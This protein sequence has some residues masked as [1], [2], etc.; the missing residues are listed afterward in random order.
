MDLGQGTCYLRAKPCI[1]GCQMTTTAT[2][3]PHP[4]PVAAP[5]RQVW[6]DFA[7]GLCIALVVMVH[8][9][10]AFLGDNLPMP[11]A[12]EA[13]NLFMDPFRIPLLMF[14]SGMLLSKSLSKPAG[15]YFWG[16]FNLIFWPFLIWSQIIYASEGRLTLEYILKTPISAPSVLWYLWFLTA[17]YGLA[18]LINRWRLPILPIMAV[19]L[20]ASELLPSFIRMDRFAALFVMF[21]AGHLAAQHLDRLSGRKL[22]GILGLAIAIAGGVWSVTVAPIKYDARFILVPF[23]LIAFILAFAQHYTTSALTAPVE[24]IGRNS[25]LFYAAHM[26][27]ILLMLNGLQRVEGL[28]PWAI[29]LGAFAAAMLAGA[30]LQVLRTR[31]QFVAAL[32]D[33]RIVAQGWARLSRRSGRQDTTGA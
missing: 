12:L 31:S 6:M 28:G 4:S 24:W 27:I 29:Y 16:K 26:P 14:L 25:M 30:L 3:D 17:F 19:S 11:P 8:T 2:T 32:F 20:I 9:R 5:Q 7:R 18:F 23:G 21:L 22:L 15:P 10:S 33:F 1:S 13:L